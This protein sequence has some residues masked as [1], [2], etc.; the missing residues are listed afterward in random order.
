M[1][2]V[3]RGHE[4]RGRRRPSHFLLPLLL[5]EVQHGSQQVDA[6]LQVGGARLDHLVKSLGGR[7]W[8]EGGI[9]ELSCLTEE[10]PGSGE[11]ALDDQDLG[12]DEVE[13]DGP[14]GQWDG[15]CNR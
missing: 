14:M 3:L 15:S 11:V 2:E 12:Q 4:R 13:G 8:G 6:L 9:K 5:S 1:E 7:V 10:R